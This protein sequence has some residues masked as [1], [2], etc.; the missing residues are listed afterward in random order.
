MLGWGILA[1]IAWIIIA[2]WPARVASRKGHSFLG[3]FILSLFFWWIT[4]FVVYFVLKDRTQT[5]PPA[6]AQ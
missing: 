4:L 3:Y 2:I 6:A 5:T 1:L